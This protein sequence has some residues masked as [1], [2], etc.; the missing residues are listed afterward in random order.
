VSDAPNN[1]KNQTKK[2]QVMETYQKLLVASVAILGT[3][4]LETRWEDIGRISSASADS[5]VQEIC[6]TLGQVNFED[7]YK[8]TEEV[9]RCNENYSS[10][11]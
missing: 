7:F 2:M 8:S 10:L 3:Y 5:L 1:F 4:L 9:V 11:Q 6:P